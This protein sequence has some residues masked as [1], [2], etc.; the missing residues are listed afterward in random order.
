MKSKKLMIK[1]I[2]MILT[3]IICTVNMNANGRNS[4]ETVPADVQQ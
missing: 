3:S 4:V 1:L 2:C